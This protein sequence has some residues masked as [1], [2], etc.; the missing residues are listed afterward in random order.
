MHEGRFPNVAF[1]AKQILGV[2]G[3]KIETEWVFSLARVLIVLKC[4]HLQVENMDPIITMVKNWLDDPHANCKP[5]SDLKQYLK[6]EKSLA[7]KNYNLI[8]KHSYN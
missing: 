6:I 1:L 3:S 2:L 8:E 4:N 7:I 5:H